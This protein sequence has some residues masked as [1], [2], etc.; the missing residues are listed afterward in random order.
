ME[1]GGES[2]LAGEEA[3]AAATAAAAAMEHE[4]WAQSTRG[5][6]E[7]GSV[8]REEAAVP[9]SHQPRPVARRAGRP[10]PDAGRGQIRP[11]SSLAATNAEAAGERRAGEGGH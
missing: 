6:T 2:C 5:S 7:Q 10:A 1:S 9:R 3:E 8:G 11:C 4:A